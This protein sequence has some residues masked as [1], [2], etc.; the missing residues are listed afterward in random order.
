M[1]A[2]KASFIAVFGCDPSKPSSRQVEEA[3]ARVN[4]E[5]ERLISAEA[6]VQVVGKVETGTVL[7]LSSRDAPGIVAEP[8]PQLL[9]AGDGEQVTQQQEELLA[10]IVF[11]ALEGVGQDANTGDLG[12]AH[13]SKAAITQELVGD[14]LKQLHIS[15][16]KELMKIDLSW[17]P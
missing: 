3:W 15:I 7:K 8:L 1:F 6:A 2:G 13:Q 11:Y 12:A 9:N 4:T 14:L 16:F 17:L 10:M 5:F